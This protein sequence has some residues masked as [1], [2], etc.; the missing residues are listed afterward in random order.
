[1]TSR[2]LNA[3][4]RDEIT[5]RKALRE[6]GAITTW[7]G[8]L[9]ARRAEKRTTNWIQSKPNYGCQQLELVLQVD[10]ATGG[11]S[12]SNI[13]GGASYNN[14]ST[15]AW[16]LHTPTNPDKKYLLN[17]GVNHLTGTNVVL[18][19][20]LLVAARNILLNTAS[21]QTVNTT[22]LTR[23]TDGV[24]VM[25]ILEVTTVFPGPSTA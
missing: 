15:G 21:A 24:G 19:V 23:Y 13:P 3:L 8:V 16:P 25:M 12:Y 6:M 9:A 18:V 1:M 4:L 2:S 5:A 10:R 7:D 14:T 20:D 11:W 17:V 22:A